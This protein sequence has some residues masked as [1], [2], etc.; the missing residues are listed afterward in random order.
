MGGIPVGAWVRVK[1]SVQSPEFGWGG[2]S[3]Q[4]IGR[5]EVVD[6]DILRIRIPGRP[7]RWNGRVHEMELAPNH[8]VP[9]VPTGMVAGAWVRVKPSVQS[10]RYKWGGVS[11][12]SVGCIRRVDSDGDLWISFQE[13]KNWR[14][15]AE[16]MEVVP[17]YRGPTESGG[18]RVGARVRLQNGVRPRYG[19]GGVS[20][21][22]VG[23]VKSITPD[24]D[25]HIDF[26]EQQG[27]HGH[28]ADLQH[29]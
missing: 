17:E 29:A 9:T 2:I 6:G 3:H 8:E 1:P 7:N 14:G 11:R 25:L 5:V 26:P 28:P 18:F 22:S 20:S 16:E 19:Q 23:T 12:G 21:G 13:A 15:R 24:G 10:P 4:S 27:W